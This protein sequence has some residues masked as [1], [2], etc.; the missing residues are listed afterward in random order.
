MVK[1]LFQIAREKSPSIIFIDEIE[2]ICGRR[3]ETESETDKKIKTEILVQTDGII[4]GGDS[5]SRVV[6]I[7]ATNFPWLIDEAMRRRLE[8]RVYVPLPDKDTIKCLLEKKLSTC[9]HGN[10]D[11][12]GDSLQGYSPADIDIVLRDA[13]MANLRRQ[14]KSKSLEE[15][16]SMD[17]VLSSTP[18]TEADLISSIKS[19]GKSVCED[20]LKEHLAFQKEFGSL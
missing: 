12:I 7:G 11:E 14:L 17:E 18:I 15:L 4:G 5:N 9:F 16:K 3:G 6:V 1:F 19:N 10:F 8:K 20:D 13:S 2:S